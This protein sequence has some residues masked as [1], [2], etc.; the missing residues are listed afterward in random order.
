MELDIMHV[1]MDAFFASVEQLDNPEFRRK[2]VIVGGIDL[3]NRGVVSTASYEARKY[4]VKSAMSV[5]EARRLCPEGIFVKGRHSRYREISEKIFRIFN[6][7]TPLVEKVSIDEAFLDL[8]GCHRLFG[9]SVEIGK[10]IKNKIKEQ[11][12]L[13]ASI[14]LSYNKFLAK[15]ASGMDKPDGFFIID[16]NNVDK[17]LNKL[18]VGE[19]WGIGKKTEQ[20]LLSKGIK[21]VG[22]LRHLSKSDLKGILGKQGLQLYYLARGI[23]DRHVEPGS[24]IKSISHEETFSDD[25]IDPDEVMSHL[26][27]MSERVARRLRK[28]CLKGSTVFIKVRYNNRVTLT[29]RTTIKEYVDDTDSIYRTGLLLIKKHN[30][31]SKPI[32]LLGIGMANLTDNNGIQLSLFTDRVRKKRLTS[33]ID[34]IKDRYGEKSITRGRNL[35]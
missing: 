25:L 29:R 24:D 26:M 33:T 16:D 21:T 2:P 1:D 7:Y 18:C 19:V 22:M 15:L 5:V 32:R 13:T 34:K 12:G 11:L 20:L 14:G 3:E 30:L 9:S 8:T 10:K 28:N 4:G 6:T 17:I 31:L 23:D 27:N 35:T